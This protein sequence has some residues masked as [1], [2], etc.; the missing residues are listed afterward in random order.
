MPQQINAE[1]D[2]IRDTLQAA[3]TGYDDTISALGLLRMIC[4]RRRK[5]S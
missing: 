2:I 5:R 3:I 1:K 4:W